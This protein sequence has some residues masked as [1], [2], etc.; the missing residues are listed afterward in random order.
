MNIEIA[1]HERMSQSGSSLLKLIQNNDMPI[2]DL[3]VRESIQNSLDAGLEQEDNVSMEFNIKSFKTLDIAKYFEGISDRLLDKYPNTKKLIEIRDVNTTGL[4]G[5][6][7]YSKV[8]DNNYGNILKLIYEISMPQEKEGSGGSWGLGKTIYFR[9]GIGLVIYYT[10]IEK[11]NGIYESRLAACLVENEEKEDSLI[12][13]VDVNRKRGI[14]WWGEK[15]IGKDETKPIT[16]EKIISEILRALNIEPYVDKETGTTI[17]IPFIEEEDLISDIYIETDT[18]PFWTRT[19]EDYINK[20]I[21]CWYAPRLENKSILKG[22]WLKVSIN[23]EYITRDTMLPLFKVIQELYNKSDHARDNKTYNNILDGVSIEKENIN[24]KSNLKKSSKIG[25]LIFVKMNEKEL[26]ME[27]PNNNK[28][29]L[30]QIGKTNSHPERNNPII[31]FTRKPG[32][33]VSYETVGEWVDGINKTEKNE[34][35]IGLF[36]PNSDN[37]IISD[38]LKEEISVEE[39]LR[40]SE[41]A[42]HT[43]WSDWT[44]NRKK[45]TIV[46]KIQSHVQKKIAKKY[47]TND[48]E[49]REVKKSSLSRTL[50]KILLPPENFGKLPTIPKKTI[51]KSKNNVTSNSAKLNMSSSPIYINGKIKIRFDIIMGY[52]TDK[53]LLKLGVLSESGRIKIEDWESNLDKGIG[54]K[55]PTE[56]EKFEIEKI[57]IENSKSKYLVNDE[58]QIDTNSDEKNYELIKVEKISSENYNTFYGVEIKKGENKKYDLTCLI[59]FAT[60]NRNLKV[61]LELIS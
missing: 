28:S 39:Y 15:I 51:S 26:L 56:I 13:Y 35:I 8:E 54:K 48:K 34:Y 9:V 52:K 58:L 57:K 36:I 24:L 19:V 40:L 38:T 41:G 1:K 45:M 37:I 46:S 18:K 2:L 31:A 53:C 50:G 61:D 55:F 33:I 49:N 6:L 20:S 10:R 29:P 14:A 59:T 7:E 21:Q 22:R 12:E 32:M 11:E 44:F 43:S 3:L 17:I 30:V 60:N 5:P 16:D 25:E 47:E 23:S 4:V 27:I 42:D